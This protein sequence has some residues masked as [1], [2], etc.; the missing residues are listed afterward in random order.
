MRSSASCNS[1]TLICALTSF[2]QVAD[3]QGP[4]VPIPQ[5][6]SEVTGPALGPMTQ[7]YVQAVGLMAYAWG[8]PLVY[9]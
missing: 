5:S 2:I 4:Q 7:A 6:A 3:A 8:W 9:V 1:L